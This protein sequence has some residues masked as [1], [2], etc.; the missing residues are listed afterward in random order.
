MPEVTELSLGEYGFLETPEFVPRLGDGGGGEGYWLRGA[1]QAKYYDDVFVRSALK[2]LDSPPED[3]PWV[4]FMPLILT[5][6]PFQ[7][8]EPY[9][10]M[11]IRENMPPAI[12]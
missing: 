4:L 11:Y 5:H 6:C 1:D 12:D 9:F 8:E 2:W 3:K 10:S 7:V